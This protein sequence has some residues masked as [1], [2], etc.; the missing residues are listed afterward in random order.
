MCD[1][2]LEKGEFVGKSLDWEQMFERD[3]DN[4]FG[5]KH[6]HFRSVGSTNRIALQLARRGYPEGTLVIADQQTA[7]RGRWQRDWYS[8][9]GKSLLFSLILCPKIPSDHFPQ[10]TLVAGVSIARA[11]QRQLG[12][13]LGIK[14]PN[15]LLFE[16]KKVCG[17]LTEGVAQPDCLVLGVGINVNQK[18]DD[19]PLQ[20][21]DTASS[22]RMIKGEGIP[23]VPLLQKILMTM[24][25]DYQESCRFG[26]TSLRDYWLQYQ[27]V[28]GKKVRLLMGEQEY[29]GEAVG[30]A[31]DGSLILRLP[32]GKEIRCGAGEVLLCR[33]DE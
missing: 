24:E 13:K 33:E 32:Q 30:L 9:P 4:I 23:I 10:L 28:L 29:K 19:F 20:I 26:F 8:A 12:I 25:E 31:E 6:F 14:W 2:F 11:I 5:Q 18:M 22:L 1:Q 15:D 27:I 21:Q 3:Q 16:G 17:I 7:G